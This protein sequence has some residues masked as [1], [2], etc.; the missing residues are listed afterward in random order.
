[1]YLVPICPSS[2]CNKTHTRVD[3]PSNTSKTLI[4]E[5]NC[6]NSG[7]IIVGAMK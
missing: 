4:H 2:K 7:H 6:V 1:M 3:V 5:G